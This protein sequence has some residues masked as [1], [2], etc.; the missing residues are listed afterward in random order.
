TYTSFPEAIEQLKLDAVDCVLG[1]VIVLNYEAQISGGT[2]MVHSFFGDEI[3]NFGIA[4]RPDDTDLI[5]ALND[6]L[7]WLL[8]D[9]INNPEANEKY[10]EIYE[11]WH[12]TGYMYYSEEEEDTPAFDFVVALVVLIGS[13]ILVIRRRRKA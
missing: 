10:N 9:D 8:G 5:N 7:D 11:K 13:S 1:D 4:C 3:E 2:K 12:G 6:A